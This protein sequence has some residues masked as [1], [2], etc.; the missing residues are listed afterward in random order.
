[1][2]EVVVSALV[3]APECELARLF[4]VRLL[5]L[6]A[7]VF[8]ALAAMI[9]VQCRHETLEIEILVLVEIVAL[10]LVMLLL[11][12]AKPSV[13]APYRLG[14]PLAACAAPFS[15]LKINFQR[16]FPAI[17]SRTC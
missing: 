6:L 1:M 14:P 7:D 17:R 12:R 10:V 3:S 15:F 8:E 5:Q 2:P 13:P 4:R 9:R 16:E 11:G